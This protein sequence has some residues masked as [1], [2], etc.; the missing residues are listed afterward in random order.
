MATPIKFAAIDSSFLLALEAGDE[1]CQGVVDGLGHYGFHFIV[2]ETVLQ[3]LGHLVTSGTD[4]EIKGRAK[5]AIIQITNW[6]FLASSLSPNEM[7]VSLLVANDLIKLIPGGD[8]NDG[9]VLAEAAY[10]KCLF[11]LTRRAEILGANRK[12]IQLALIGAD[13]AGLMVVSPPELTKVLE[14][15]SK[16]QK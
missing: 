15:I 14:D 4:A 10:N 13:L 8:I 16:L 5:N 11:L 6:G 7:G 1:E 3:E 12:S 2:T 9:L